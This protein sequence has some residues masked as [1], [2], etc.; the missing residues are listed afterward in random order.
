MHPSDL[1]G[2]WIIEGLIMR[3]LSV[4]LLGSIAALAITVAASEAS[5]DTTFYTSESA[6]DAAI[7]TSIT[8]T[9]DSPGYATLR[10]NILGSHI[11]ATDAQMNK[12][13]GETRYTTTGFK[14]SNT[15]TNPFFDGPAYCAGCNGS[16]ILDFRHTSV[17]TSKGV[18][19]VGFDF[20]N[21]GPPFGPQYTAFITFGD[22]SSVNELLPIQPSTVP[23]QSSFFGVTSDSLISSIALGLPDGG[24]TQF[25][26]FAEDNLTIGTS[27]LTVP[28][29]IA[30]AGLL[31]VPGPIA[32][33]GLPGL[34]MASGGL[35]G[36]WRRRKIA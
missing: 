18:Y 5:A 23:M 34:I 2:R 7:G 20:V 30:G 16:F 13:F 4:K 8:D 27:P 25:G 33:A 22:K 14:D 15:I 10:F 26:F 24:T 6:F 1:R 28:G 21:D 31:A 29:P 19:G 17:G 36:W 3:S 9:Y 35:L 11:G 12:V 32:G